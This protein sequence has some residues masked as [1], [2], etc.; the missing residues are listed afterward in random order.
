MVRKVTGTIDSEHTGPGI[1][2]DGK[3]EDGKLVMHSKV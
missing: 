1:V 2:T 3:W